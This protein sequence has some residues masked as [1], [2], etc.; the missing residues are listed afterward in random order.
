[1]RLTKEQNQTV[2]QYI[3]D[4]IDSEPYEVETETDQEKLAFL[5]KTFQAE[6]GWEIERGSKPVI[7]IFKDWLQGLPTCFNIEFE[8]YKIL[9]LA[10]SWETLPE[11]PTEKQ[12]DKILNNYWHFI[13]N[14]TMLLI[15]KRG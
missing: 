14:K 7:E 15:N 10:K 9:E 13:A 1:M 2:R 8:N 12:E 11:N 4:S 3:I 6:K 5:Y